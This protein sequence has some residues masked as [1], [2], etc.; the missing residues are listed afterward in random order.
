M[1]HV[2][3][4]YLFM[5][6]AQL[7]TG[8][9]PT[10]SLTDLEICHLLIH[11]WTSRGYLNRPTKLLEVFS[12]LVD[13]HGGSRLCLA[14][15]ALA[16][17]I[18]QKKDRTGSE[19]HGIFVSLLKFLQKLGR[20]RELVDSLKALGQIRNLPPRLPEEMARA[21]Y[22]HVLALM[23]HEVYVSCLRRPGGPEWSPDTWER[24]ADK[25]IMDP[26]INP[27][28]I[29]EALEIEMH[30]RRRK[31]R[32]S[33]Q[34]QSRN[35][36]ARKVAAVQTLAQHFAD[37]AHLRPRVALR[38]VSQC[39]SYLEANKGELTPGVVGALYRVVTADLAEGWPGRTERL[40]W[41]L[42]VVKR[43]YGNDVMVKCGLTL[44][45]WRAET[46]RLLR[47]N[48]SETS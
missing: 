14:S 10:L 26:A 36:V 21:S 35:L 33:P 34:R 43:C 2:E 18:S 6:S 30:D 45:R 40:R 31:P 12:S 44:G 24:Y 23:I 28:K 48:G 4:D 46:R 22:N 37:A 15:L 11:Q 13:S 20:S 39:V 1:P 38:H 7:F 32:R 17:R 29:W 8:S 47:A 25:I 41:L 27:A 5:V 3:Q 42:R 16:V 19:S 9:D